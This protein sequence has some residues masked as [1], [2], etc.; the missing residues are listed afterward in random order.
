LKIGPCLAAI[1][2]LT[3]WPTHGSLAREAHAHRV[4]APAAVVPRVRPPP[5]N[6][7]VERA[8]VES[9]GPLETGPGPTGQSVNAPIG[10]ARLGIRSAVQPPAAGSGAGGLA[11]TGVDAGGARIVRPVS[12]PIATAPAL[13]S[14]RIDGARLIRPALAP[15]GL[16]GPA[17]T[18][19]GIN[20]TTFRPKH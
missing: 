20:G 7:A 4:I 13:S 2:L 9:R 14:G 18:A 3:A 6:A 11:N 1:M 19:V 15:V 17:K 10:D 12:S 16:G 5:G 8:K